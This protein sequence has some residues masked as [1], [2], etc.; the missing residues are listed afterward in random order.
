MTV[1]VVHIY[2]FFLSLLA[3]C[4]AAEAQEVFSGT[5]QDAQTGEPVPGAAVTQGKNWAITDS[6]GVFLLK[7]HDK[8]PLTITSLGY[9]TLKAEPVKGGIYRLQPDIFALQE[10]VVTAQ[11]ER[12]VT[13]TSV[14]GKD[15]IEHIQ[16]SSIKDVLELLPGGHAVDP[17]LASPQVA[18]LRSAASISANYATSALGTAVLVDGKPVGNNANLQSSPAYSN[19][20]SSYV[21]YGTDLRTITTEDIE[22]VEVVRGI[23]SVE[24]GDLTSGLMKITRKRGGKTLRARFKADMSSKLFYVGK[25]FQWKTF[26]LNVGANYLHSMADPRNPRQNYQRITGTVRLGKTWKKEL[27]YVLNASLDYTGSFDN[28]KSDQNLDFGT[29]GPIETYF[30]SYNKLDAGLDFSVKARDNASAFRSWITTASLTV[31]NDRIKRWKYVIN[32][33]EQPYSTATEPGEW[34]ALILPV[35]YESNLEVKGLPLYAFLQSAVAFKWGEQRLKAGLQWTLDKNLGEGTVFDITRPFSS[36][37]S[38]R[39]RPYYAIPANH[40]L[41]LYAEE[42][43][44][45]QLGWGG[46]EWSA[47]VRMS[48][49]LGAGKAFRINGRPYVDPRAN[50]RFNFPTAIVKGHRLDAGVY[51]GA[52]LHTKF[53][54]MDMLY[55]EPVYGDIQEFNYWPVEA[56]LRRSY[57]YVYKEDPTNYALA[58][59]RNFKWEVGADVS[60]NGFHLS[61]DYFRENMTSGFRSSSRYG[62]YVVKRYDGS[63]IDK[64]TLTAPPDVTSLPWKADT[65]LQ[66]H[67]I[68]TNG[69][70]TLKQGVEFTFAAPRIK[71]INTRITANGAW[72]VTKNTNSAPLYYVPSAIVNGS[73]YN[74]VGYYEVNDGSTYTQLNTNIMLDT[75]IPRLG[76]ILS[77]S[78][79]TS[80]FSNHYP[81]ARSTKPISYLDKNL[82]EHPYTEVE[83]QDPVLRYLVLEESS[84]N[85]NYLVPFATYFNLKATKKFLHDKMGISLFVNRLLAIAPDYYMNGA[86]V[87]RSSTPYF[88]MEIDF[89]L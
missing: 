8:S 51:A 76:L 78:C 12:G 14:I 82:V 19:L 2:S 55:P 26:T 88:G 29:M 41:S 70:Q 30:S 35:R 74:Y 53:P 27:E 13:A 6:L 22:S 84:M 39:P 32:G 79:Q 61:V 21:N 60:W 64:N 42:N 5:V 33:A 37:T 9:K 49:L 47:G 43:G 17:N 83:A 63:G 57:M 87:R 28:Q 20:G 68:T 36:V 66:A 24:Y 40:R 56:Q 10:V 85:Y 45:A 16:P 62:R 44:S 81:I 71:A 72:F 18:N 48:M 58:P 38:A 69:S 89:K 65:L 3:F 52:G 31:E 46:L 73:R 4:V 7:T 77:I 50:I 59:A 75:Q 11:E 15:A 23:A 80:W 25:D 1:K 34:D 67:G 54:T 86:F